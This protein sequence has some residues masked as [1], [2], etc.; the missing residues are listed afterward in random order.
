VRAHGSSVS[1]LLV[2]RKFERG[3]LEELCRAGGVK[4]MH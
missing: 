1:R 3:F 2:M 4:E